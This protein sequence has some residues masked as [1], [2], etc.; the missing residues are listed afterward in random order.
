MAL[1]DLTLLG[2]EALVLSVF[3]SLPLVGIAALVGLVTSW[4]QAAASLHDAAIAHLPRLIAVALAVGTLATW[5][6][7]Q[8]VAFAE[9]ALG[10]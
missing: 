8:I 9:R 2:Q 7:S 1:E 4:V 10:G 6:G 5:M 3:L